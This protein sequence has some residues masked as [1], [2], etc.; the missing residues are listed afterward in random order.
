MSNSDAVRLG[1]FILATVGSL[2]IAGRSLIDPKRYGFFRFFGFEAIFALILVNSPSWFVEPLS[3]PQIGS[4][5]LL[6]GSVLL[7][8][9][10]YALLR[11]IGKPTGGIEKTTRLVDVGVY[12]FIRHPLYASLVLFSCGALLKHISPLAV[13][14]TIFASLCLI[15]TALMEERENLRKFGGSYADY[16]RRTRR[17][18]PF[19]F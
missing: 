19:V 1:A 13:C 11:S 16:L 8:V 12:R 18:L 14:L 5:I 3:L 17:F 15:L 4:W 6:S 10:S 2:A 7:A 9:Y